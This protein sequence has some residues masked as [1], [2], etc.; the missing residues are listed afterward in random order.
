M[1]V[2]EQ[3][4]YPFLGPELRFLEQRLAERR[5]VLGICLGAQLIAQAVGARVYPG[6][7]KEIGFGP[8]SLS[9]PGRHSPLGAVAPDQPVLHWHGD[10]YDLPAGATLL[11]SSAVYPQQAFS[12]GPNVLAL[13]F[14]LE[15]GGHMGRWLTGHADELREAG[16]DLARLEQD[17][18][19]HS[20]AL[21]RIAGAVLDGWLR[22]LAV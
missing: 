7:C 9:K 3:Q 19:R 10:T 11:A 20:P 1:G 18:E 22:G 17:A 21:R 2:Y 15:A 5:P 6:H 8:I 14:H 13:Q 12:A 16:V 4:R